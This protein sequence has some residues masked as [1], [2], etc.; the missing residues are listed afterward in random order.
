MTDNNYLIFSLA[1]II[2]F[3]I[4]AGYIS[5]KDYRNHRIPN[6]A[7]LLF[8]ISTLAVGTIAHSGHSV[9]HYYEYGF[10]TGF[11]FFI[12][13]LVTNLASR[14][15]LGMGDVKLAFPL[16][17]NIGLVNSDYLFTAIII[18]TAIAGFYALY[19]KTKGASARD[20]VP[21]APFLF[22]GSAI[23][24]CLSLAA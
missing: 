20:A 13:L 9:S 17:F 21:F 23:A 16:G 15:K 7:T 3:V 11:F 1:F 2:N 4:W 24:L 12:I 6:R 10:L 14:G 22:A 19:R 5:V 8:T 18:S